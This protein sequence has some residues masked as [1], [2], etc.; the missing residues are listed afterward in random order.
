LLELKMSQ[1]GRLPD[2]NVLSSLHQQDP[3]A[4]EDFRRKVLNEFVESAPLIHRAT[5][6]QLV[7]RIESA[8][9]AAANPMEALMIA[10]RMMH[11]SLNQLHDAWEQA[12]YAV[13]GLQT[14]VVLD[15][16]CKQAR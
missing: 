9:E 6:E 12:R 11:E 3:E 10:S 15:R 14:A 16:L 4:F 7:R 13:A 5:L 1:P 8:R 2:F